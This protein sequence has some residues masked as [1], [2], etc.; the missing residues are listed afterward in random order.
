VGL[1]PFLI[2]N[3]EV[4]RIV[5]PAIA[6]AE[7]RYFYLLNGDLPDSYDKDLSSFN[8][9]I[10]PLT[11]EQVNIA[12]DLAYA[13]RHELPFREHNRDYLIAGQCIQLVDILITYNKKHFEPL[14]LVPTRILTPEEF[15]NE[16]TPM[17]DD[18]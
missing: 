7:R 6:Y 13:H 16:F 5:I 10:L 14:D 9:E 1:V 15:L 2:R 17:D 11:R 18:V 3:K 8:A 4:F 12:I